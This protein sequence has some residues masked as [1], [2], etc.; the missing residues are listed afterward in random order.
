MASLV[1]CGSCARRC[2]ERPIGAYWRWLRS[3]GVW[4]KHYARLCVGCY[5]SR[6]APLE[7]EIDPD[8]RLSCPQCGIDTEDDYDAI[9]I[10]AFPG[11]RGQVDVS[12]PFCGVHAAEY[13]I[14]L[15]EFAR[16]LDTVDGAPEP[17]QHAPTT[18]DTLRSLGR[19][20]EVGRRG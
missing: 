20:P 10:T 4:K 6:V 2:G 16:E 5:A 15:L 1:K 11:G 8:A 18:E 13:R 14:W 17:R 19:D 7:G 9:Y 12:A 3:D